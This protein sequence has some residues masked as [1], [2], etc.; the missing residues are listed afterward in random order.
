MIALF[1]ITAA[2]VGA[3]GATSGPPQV[4]SSL[5]VVQPDPRLCPSPLCGGHWVALAN[6]ARTRCHDGPLRP[7]CY[8]ARTVDEERHPLGV[9]VP[10]GAL[11]RAEIE[12]WK[13]EGFGMLGTLVVADVFSPAG[14]APPKGRFFRL[15]D[16]GVRCI[17]A[18]CFSVR[19]SRVNGSLRTTVSGIDIG[20]ARATPGELVRIEAA[21]GTKNG[22]LAQGRI[23]A[24]PNGGRSFLATRF[25]LRSDR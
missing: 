25:F 8:V 6:H 13:Y 20:A 9:E 11:V 16:T 7:R 2:L 12:P 5:Y 10:A 4:G 23:V 17:R 1:A 15:A 19:A 3:G 21:L 22:V 14:R 24:A 18:P